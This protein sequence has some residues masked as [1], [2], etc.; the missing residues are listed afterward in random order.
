[1]RR[2][3][4]VVLV[5]IS[6]LA[7]CSAMKQPYPLLPVA[8][9]EKMVVGRLDADY[10]GD[11]NCLSKCHVHDKIRDFYKASVHGEQIKPETGLPLVNC[12]SCHGPGS[13]A[14]SR[15]EKTRIQQGERGNRCDSG[16]LL[17]L[18]RL[19]PQA[20]SLICLKCHS[21]SSSP[22][23]AHWNT[24][25]H[26]LGQLSC[27]SCHR[28]HDGPQQKVNHEK[29]AELCY[30]CHLGVKAQFALTSHH[31]VRERKVD[32]FDC[33]EAHG[34]AGPTMLKGNT[35][36]ELCIRCH[37]DKSGPFAYEHG[38]VTGNCLNCHT[39][40]GSVNRRL[41]SAA[42]PF[43]CIQCHTPGHSG[44]LAAGQKRLFA[45]RCSDC[46]TAVHGSNVPD[47]N[48]SSTLRR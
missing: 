16:T 19:P 35:V 4:P 23:L 1:M 18:K 46:H 20:Q 42:M 9:Y 29:M 36:R 22:A 25:A 6:L 44:V 28:L 13:L 48:G 41:L 5:V 14:V 37:M 40:H 47:T 38:D 34:T 21:V 30:T 17:E 3:F 33:H 45:N 8:E 39:A 7:A 11:V 32:C 2:L 24:S 15:I 43:L 10:I 27:F 31:P 12:E 26:A